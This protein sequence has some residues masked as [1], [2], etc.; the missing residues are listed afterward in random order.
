MPSGKLSKV[1]PIHLV[2][3]L[4]GAPEKAIVLASGSAPQRHCVGFTKVN[5]WIHS[6]N[7][8][9]RDGKAR[10]RSHIFSISRFGRFDFQLFIIVS[11]QC[12]LNKDDG[13]TSTN[14]LITY[15][16]LF[17]PSPSQGLRFASSRYPG[18]LEQLI[19]ARAKSRQKIRF[20]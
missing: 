13:T 7:P 1:G 6:N 2:Q 11:I 15:L 9:K 10:I 18:A 14:S 4:K 16:N 17:D 3:L 12:Y 5:A 19:C 20:R 8:R